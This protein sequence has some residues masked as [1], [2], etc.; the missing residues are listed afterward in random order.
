MKD[1][2]AF[3]D[4]RRCKNW[5]HKIWK[6]L[7]EALFCQVS[8]STELLAPG[9][10]LGSRAS[11]GSA[12][13]AAHGSVPAEAGGSAWLRP[14]VPCVR[15]RY[16]EGTRGAAPVLPRAPDT[17]QLAPG[18]PLDASGVPLASPEGVTVSQEAGR[19]CHCPRP[20]PPSTGAA[21]RVR[22]FCPSFLSWQAYNLL[23]FLI[24]G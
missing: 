20:A 8:Q 11:C 2:S 1:F 13:A 19:V 3:L 23:L 6:R 15:A 12:A 4:K 16:A 9:L 10:T 24:S 14:Q 17:G 21:D 5:A 18:A 7:S 22:G